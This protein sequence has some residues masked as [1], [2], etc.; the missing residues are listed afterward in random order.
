VK[1]S[2]SSLIRRAGS[3]NGLVDFKRLL[4]WAPGPRHPPEIP[5]VPAFP[6][7]LERIYRFTAC[8]PQFSFM[9][10]PRSTI[11]SKMKLDLEV[12]QVDTFHTL[13]RYEGTGTVYGYDQDEPG[14]ATGMGQRTCASCP[15][16]T[17]VKPCDPA[18]G[19]GQR[20]CASCPEITC[21]KACD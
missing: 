20:T 9:I 2:P 3:G 17:C 21:V 11:M 6:L 8:S 10:S 19:M 15:E 5:Q 18:T 7:T 4:V 14:A 1:P 13:S 12:L 16:I